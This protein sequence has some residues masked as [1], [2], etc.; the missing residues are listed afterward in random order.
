MGAMSVIRAVS[1]DE[2]C[3]LAEE[4]QRRLGWAY[5]LGWAM[6]IIPGA[7]GLE[8]W[9]V[10]HVN[11]WVVECYAHDYWTLFFG[12]VA[13]ILAFV[14]H[15]DWAAWSY[16]LGAAAIAM[17][18]VGLNIGDVLCPEYVGPGPSTPPM[19]PFF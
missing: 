10:R 3:N 8:Y 15:R 14:N 7:F 2:R 11:G 12:V 5:F 6:V 9:E 19:F 1:S 18:G 16:G 13:L 17:I 4:K